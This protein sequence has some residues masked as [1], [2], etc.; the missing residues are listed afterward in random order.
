MSAINVLCLVLFPAGQNIF[1]A[2][3]S[4]GVMVQWIQTW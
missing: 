1:M 3:R 2:Q 4:P